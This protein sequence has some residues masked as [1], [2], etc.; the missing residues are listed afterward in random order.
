MGKPNLKDQIK[1]L[2]LVLLEEIKIFILTIKLV[3][4]K[5]NVW[6]ISYYHF[7]KKVVVSKKQILNLSRLLLRFTLLSIFILF[8]L[9]LISK[10][11]T[12][13]ILTGI[14]NF[15][16]KILISL[17]N[18]LYKAI[19]WIYIIFAIF[20]H[21][22]NYLLVLLELTLQ[23][24]FEWIEIFFFN[25]LIYFLK[26]I[27]LLYSNFEKGILIFLMWLKSRIKK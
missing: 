15:I 26:L 21:F 5:K 27:F 17:V 10:Y 13:P 23:P 18:L 16:F 19:Y 22:M 25:S 4:S 6:I 8:V 7:L 1:Q 20:L 14:F 2:Y 24:I 3:I 9:D 12:A 11:I